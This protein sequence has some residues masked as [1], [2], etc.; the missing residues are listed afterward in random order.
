MFGAIAG[1]YAL[2]IYPIGELFI[3]LIVMTVVPLVFF[4]LFSSTAGLGDLRKIGILGGR[5]IIYYLLTTAIA[6]SI[7]LAIANVTKPGAGVHLKEL[8]KVEEIMGKVKKANPSIVETLVKMVPTNPAKAL[9]E[10]NMLQIIFFALLLGVS[11]LAVKKEYR[12]IVIK[13]SQGLSDAMINM[14]NIIMKTAPYGVFALAAGVVAKQ[15]VKILSNLA[16]YSIVVIVGLAIQLIFLLVVL[17]VLGRVK[18]WT[19]LKKAWGVLIFAFST[20]SSNATLPLTIETAEQK[21]GVPN[22]VASF[23]LPLGATVN[24]NGTAL[25]QGVA[26]VFIAQVFGIPLTVSDQLKIV[27]TATLAAIGTA[28]V[29][30]VGIIMLTLVL[31]SVNIPVEGIAL[32]LGV[33]RFLDMAR[34]ILNVGGDLI[35]SIIMARFEKGKKAGDG[36]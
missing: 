5:I 23:V 28:G 17:Y 1:K 9:A 14:V 20:S 35:G 2:I 22:Y 10:G 3:R 16:W 25:Y 21:F 11:I 12:D 15:G 18:P 8:P 27:L 34:T 33:D 24:M 31:R 19:F 13:G 6:I 36:T 30:G 4:S 26:A 32:I 29:P 7:G